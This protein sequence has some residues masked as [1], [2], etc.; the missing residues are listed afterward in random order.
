MN[1]LDLQSYLRSLHAVEEPSVDRVIVGNPQAEVRGIATAWMPTFR[2]CREALALGCNTLVVHEPTFYTHWD[3]DEKGA[4]YHS[5]RPETK[6]A[7]LEMV[8]E[9]RRWIEENGLVILRCH[10]VLDGLEGSGIPYAFG[11]LLGFTEAQLERRRPFYHVYRVELATAGEVARQ[12]AANVRAIGQP[13]VGFYGDPQ[14]LVSTVGVGTGCYSDPMDFSDLRPDLFITI[15]DV[16]RTWTQ[17]VFAEDSGWPMVVL[18]HGTSEEAGV[19]RLA[20]LLREAF[21]DVPV[22]H[23]PGGCSYRWITA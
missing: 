21:P 8:A 16:I 6:T 10:D 14:R 18:D 3:L 15:N 23:I 4:D 1:A 20:G 2:N 9:K 5:A 19:M 17:G 7:Y 12:I 11:E 13:G 22:H